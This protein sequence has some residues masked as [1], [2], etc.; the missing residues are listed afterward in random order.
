MGT[1][2]AQRPIATTD[3]PPPG[4]MPTISR[5]LTHLTREVLTSE[6][7]YRLS[8]N[9]GQLLRWSGPASIR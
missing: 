2:W 4:T 7:T 5:D 3:Q 1:L 8:A 9:P 6:S